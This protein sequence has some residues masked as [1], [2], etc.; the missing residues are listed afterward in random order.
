VEPTRLC[1]MFFDTHAQDNQGQVI[2]SIIKHE[3]RNRMAI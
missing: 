2:L 1:G 3:P